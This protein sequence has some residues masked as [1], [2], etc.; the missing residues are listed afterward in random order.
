[1]FHTKFHRN[2]IINED[3]K[4]LRGGRGW[5]ALIP[6]NN[7]F[8]DIWSR[9]QMKVILNLIKKGTVPSKHLQTSPLPLPSEMA[10]NN[11]IRFR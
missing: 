2:R 5:G 1:M 6:I 8:H 3:F 7:I 11:C 9:N 4:I 10:K